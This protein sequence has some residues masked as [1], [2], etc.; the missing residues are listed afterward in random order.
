V[1]FYFD[2]N[3]IE[4]Q[5]YE[6]MVRSLITQLSMQSTSTPKALELLFSSCM[7]GQRQP[8]TSALLTTLRELIQE[9]D[10]TYIVLD[11]LDECKN[12]QD[13]LENMEKIARW[14]LRKLHILAT[15]RRETD[16]REMFDSLINDQE[17]ICIQNALVN[18][19]IRAY[20]HDR[21]RT[22][23]GLRRW[24][25]QPKVQNEIEMTLTNKADGM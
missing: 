13:L 18:D 3:D 23:R 5:K 14:K 8:E 21:L 17:E 1:Y 19:D 24:Q 16:I 7:S 9:F 10:E 20:V 12:R 11:A 25:N 6:R 22:D 4:K 15:S 2:F